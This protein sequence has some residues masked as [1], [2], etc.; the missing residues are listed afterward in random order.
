MDPPDNL[1]LTYQNDPSSDRWPNDAEYLDWLRNLASA[2]TKLSNKVWVSV[3]ARWLSKLSLGGRVFI[4]TY[5]FGN[6]NVSQVTNAY[7]PMFRLSPTTDEAVW[8]PEAVRV[9]S[10]RARMGDKRRAAADKN[11]DDI[12]SFP[13]VVGNAPERRAWHPTQ[14]PEA[15]YE[16]ILRYSLGATPGGLVLDCFAGSGTCY[17]SWGR[18]DVQV[19]GI[20]R[21][22]TYCDN[23]RDEHDLVTR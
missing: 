22:S 20:E 5:T 17:R 18:Y 4:W 12:L 8:H 11:P 14:H 21:S 9:Q 6:Y 19:A 10:A 7:R 16:W 1:G 23:L 3:N 13:R 2:A 15:L